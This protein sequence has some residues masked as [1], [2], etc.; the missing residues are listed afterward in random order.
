MM[1][2]AAAGFAGVAFVVPLLTARP[3]ALVV[4]GLIGLLL[5][6]LGIAALW[7]WPVT[8]AACVFLVEYAAALWLAS[9]SPSVA[10]PTV[11]GL[12]LLFLLQSVELARS[13]RRSTVDAAVIRSQILAWIGFGAGTLAATLLLVAATAGL[14]ATIPSTAA[15]FLAAVGALGVLLTLAATVRGGWRSVRRSH[16][17]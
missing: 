15:P 16:E 4:T 17:A 10:G 14:A 1:R 11:L 7:R 12:S 6:A 9:T 3:Q 8:A 5:A 13:T 2:L